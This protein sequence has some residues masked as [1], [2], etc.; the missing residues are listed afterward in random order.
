MK[1]L[2]LNGMAYTCMYERAHQKKKKKCSQ[3]KKK[4]K[5][6]VL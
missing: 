5:G 6:I 4:K 2:H 1:I 3:L